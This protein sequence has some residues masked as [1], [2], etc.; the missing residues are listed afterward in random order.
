MI[1]KKHQFYVLVWSCPDSLTNLRLNPNSA[2]TWTL[3][4]HELMELKNHS[5]ACMSYRKAIGSLTGVYRFSRRIRL[6]SR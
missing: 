2:S 3:I 1:I 4:G 5:A 6:I